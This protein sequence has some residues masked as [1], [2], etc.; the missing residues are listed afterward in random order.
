MHALK[1]LLA[2]AATSLSITAC[3]SGGSSLV[4]Q[5]SRAPLANASDT[6][7]STMASWTSLE[8]AP[9]SESKRL[10]AAPWRRPRTRSVTSATNSS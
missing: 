3:A 4:T 10:P 9:T 5:P 7:R 6:C 2:V 8:S 1:T